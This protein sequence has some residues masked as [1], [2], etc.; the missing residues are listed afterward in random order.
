MNE[1]TSDKETQDMKNLIEDWNFKEYV[2]IYSNNSDLIKVL[3]SVFHNDKSR[4]MWLLLSNNCKKE[5]YLKEMAVIIEKD[6]NP[7]LPNY[8]Y[9][10]A[11]MVKAGIVLVR[12]KLHNKH[13]T[14]FYRAAP[15]VM[16]TTPDIYEKASKSKTLK[17]TFK[18]VFKFAVIGVAALGIHAFSQFINRPETITETFNLS[19]DSNFTIP[20]AVIIFGLLGVRIYSHFKNKKKLKQFN[21]FFKL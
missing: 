20:L 13:K 1:E 3:G 8:E 10:I 14:K 7:R 16:L 2:K 11:I 9:H 21:S 4:E 6:D 19:G 17:N 5:Y 18:K 12:V 15:V